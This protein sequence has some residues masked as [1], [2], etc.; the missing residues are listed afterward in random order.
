[1]KT[2][3]EAHESPEDRRRFGTMEGGRIARS[4]S[5]GRT[6]RRRFSMMR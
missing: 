5:F 4:I 3:A 6:M 1:M 2:A